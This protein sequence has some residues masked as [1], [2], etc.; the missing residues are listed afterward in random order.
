MPGLQAGALLLGYWSGY[1]FKSLCARR[2][3]IAKASRLGRLLLLSGDSGT[4]ISHCLRIAGIAAR[5]TNWRRPIRSITSRPRPASALSVAEVMA[6][7]K[8]TLQASLSVKSSSP[9][10]VIRLSRCR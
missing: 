1:L 2:R 6:S 7:L 4:R 10:S 3:A 8:K 9:S 5:V